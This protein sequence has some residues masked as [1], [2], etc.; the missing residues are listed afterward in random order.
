MINKLENIAVNTFS[1]LCSLGNE[2]D[3][4]KGNIPQLIFPN[5]QQPKKSNK[6]RIS[7]Q[8]GKLIFIQNIKSIDLFY[9]IE[10][11]TL[12]KYNFT[13][14][15][16]NARAGSLDLCIFEKENDFLKRKVNI[17]FKAHNMK[18]Y[19]QDFHKLL[20]EPGDSMF[21]HILES[22]NNGTLRGDNGRKGVFPKYKEAF[23]KMKNR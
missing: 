12:R 21:F 20:A 3:S 19:H 23:D 10:T 2:R 16:G 9:S 17:E 22:V 14:K 15:F 8:E 7:E 11:P 1:V 6:I 4:I 13:S 5:D 18:E